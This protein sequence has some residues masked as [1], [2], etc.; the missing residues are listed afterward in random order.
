MKAT[1]VY[2]IG[3]LFLMLLSVFPCI[4][5]DFPTKPVTIVIP[6]VAGGGFDI[7]SRIVAKHM[8]GTLN[9][10]MIVE[11]RPGGSGV[12]GYNYVAR[13]QPDGHTITMIGTPTLYNTLTVQ[14]IPFTMDSFA[15]IAYINYEPIT[16]IVKKGG[17]LDMPVDKLFAYVKQHPNEIIAGTGGRWVSMHIATEYLEMLTGMKFRKVHFNGTKDATTALLGGHVDMMMN[18]FSDSAA[19]ITSGQFKTVAVAAEKKDPFMPNTPTF[20][21]LGI[22]ILTGTWRAFAAPA[23]TPVEALTTLEEAF[24]AV[25]KKPEV[26]DDFR[27]INLT[28]EFRDR[29]AVAKIIESDLKIYKPL[30]EKLKASGE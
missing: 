6:Y 15:P 24:K 7:N 9:Q 8:V 23:K 27:K 3:L 11:N 2:P 1:K 12:V 14:N 10:P 5:A 29:K 13:S 30:I 19:F 21:D 22:D 26:I 25:L 16:M 17:K 18:Y 28:L 20:R 4:A